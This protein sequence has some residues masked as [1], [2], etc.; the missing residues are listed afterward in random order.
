VKFLPIL[1]CQAPPRKPKCFRR[2]AKP[3]YWKL[4]GDGSAYTTVV[5][6]YYQS[7]NCRIA[8]HALQYCLWRN[9]QNSFHNVITIDDLIKNY[10]NGI[11][12]QTT[13]AKI[14]S[15]LLILFDLLKNAVC[16][17]CPINNNFELEAPLLQ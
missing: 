11:Y 6:T 5:C 4:S 7:N 9:K 13:V 14:L 16:I 3:P 10:S 15:V 17:P 8:A 1:E 12:F 2:R